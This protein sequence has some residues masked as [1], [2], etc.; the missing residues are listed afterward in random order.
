MLVTFNVL[1]KPDVRCKTVLT[2]GFAALLARCGDENGV[3]V[4][5]VMLP[6][7]SLQLNSDADLLRCFRSEEQRDSK[8]IFAR[9]V[10]GMTW[11]RKNN[12]TLIM[13]TLWRST[14]FYFKFFSIN[15]LILYATLLKDKIKDKLI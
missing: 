6:V 4:S 12:G 9:S 2:L 3:I 15:F 14:N 8:L 13:K 11:K 10:R 5:L 7:H 1:R